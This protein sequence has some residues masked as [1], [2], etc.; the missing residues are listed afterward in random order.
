MNADNSG[1]VGQERN[2]G[3]RRGGDQGVKGI[4]ERI[5]ERSYFL[6]NFNSFFPLVK[7]RHVQE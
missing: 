5:Y 4:K 6:L 2:V 1:Q 7:I 3:E